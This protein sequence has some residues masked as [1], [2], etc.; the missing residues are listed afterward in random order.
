M[1]I[2]EIED[3]IEKNLKKIIEYY[4]IALHEEVKGASVDEIAEIAEELIFI[5]EWKKGNY[6]VSYLRIKE[7][8]EGTA[9][10]EEAIEWLA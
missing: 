5:R 4:G 8:T 3:F 10:S 6:K 7:A 1:S 2:Y 9:A